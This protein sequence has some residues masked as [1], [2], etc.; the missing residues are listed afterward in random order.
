MSW[1]ID[2]AAGATQRLQLDVQCERQGGRTIR[3]PRSGCQRGRGAT[4][5]AGSLAATERHIAERRA[6]AAELTSS[7]ESFNGWLQRS[8]A[9]LDMLI[10]ETPDGPLCLC[11]HSLVLTAFGRDGL[12]TALECLWLD[13]ALAAGTLRFLAAH[14]AIAPRPDDRCRAGQ[15]P[16]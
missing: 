10:T 6:R 7:N 1:P 3:R 5:R 4:T 14:Q 16:A 9:D 8:R 11:R 15:D 12:I 2:L 13:P